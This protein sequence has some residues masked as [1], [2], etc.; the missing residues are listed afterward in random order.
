MIELEDTYTYEFQFSQE[1][2][3]RFA[4]V[5]GDHNPIHLDKEFA[6]HS[7]FKKPIIH[8]FLSGSIFSK[9]FGTLFPGQGTI[10]KKQ[11]MEF[12]RPMYVD[13]AYEALFR[14]SH[15]DRAKHEA[16]V[17]T[18]IRDKEKKKVTIQGE[19]ILVHQNKI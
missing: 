4:D 11:N 3:N 13:V 10:Y 5:S 12:K 17:E 15:I 14:V 6:S 2:V 16:T 18:I 19:A 1:D 9:V 7:I 8:G